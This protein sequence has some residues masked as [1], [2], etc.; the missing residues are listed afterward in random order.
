[1]TGYDSFW[2]AIATIV[3][4]VMMVGAFALTGVFMADVIGEGVVMI[5]FLLLAAAVT[6]TGFIWGWGRSGSRNRSRLRARRWDFDEDEGFD[7]DDLSQSEKRKRDRITI[8]LRNLSNDELIRLQNRISSGEIDDELLEE[9][10]S[11][12]E[13]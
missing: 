7:D 6:S 13:R 3:I 12:R 5:V 8:A 9:I 10:L 4:W 11:D 2:R 1:M